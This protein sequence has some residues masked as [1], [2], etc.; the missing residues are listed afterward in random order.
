MAKYLLD[1]KAA[2]EQFITSPAKRALTT[3]RYFAETYNH[4]EIQKKENLYE[5]LTEDFD[6]LIL[7]LDDQ[8][9]S[10][11]LFSHNPSLS[12][13]ASLLI[14]NPL[15][16]PPCSIAIIE[17]DTEEWSLLHAAPKRLKQFL[18]PEDFQ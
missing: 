13:Y 17:I 5:P 6:R 11:A 4:S 2:I 7:R 1:Q 12:D 10:V 18:T 14:R 16:L 9:R 15:H 8:W 3:C